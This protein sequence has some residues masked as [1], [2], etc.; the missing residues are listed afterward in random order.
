MKHNK[1][2]KYGSAQQIMVIAFYIT[3]APSMWGIAATLETSHI[4]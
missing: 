1:D 4:I 3:S 2:N